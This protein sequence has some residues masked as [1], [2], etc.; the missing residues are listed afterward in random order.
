MLGQTT[1]FLLIDERLILWMAGGLVA[2]DGILFVFA[3][4]VFQR[5][6]I[7]TRWK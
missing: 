6:T 3:T 2:L 4:R 5:E 1:G 7:L